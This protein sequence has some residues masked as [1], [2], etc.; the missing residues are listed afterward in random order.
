MSFDYTQ[1][2]AFKGQ[3]SHVAPR[4]QHRLARSIGLGN[5]YLKF[6]ASADRHL[7]VIEVGCGD[8]RF[9]K[10]LREAGFSNLVGVDPSA[11]YKSVTTEIPILHAYANDYLDQCLDDSVGTI[12]AFDVFEHIPLQVLRDLFALARRK[13][14][15][16]GMIVFRI[17]NMSSPLALVNFFGDTSHVTALNQNSL[18]QIF[19]D[20]GLHLEEVSPEPLAYPRSLLDLAGIFAWYVF[21]V[22]YGLV[23]RAFGIRGR[24]LTPN[25]VCTVR[26]LPEADCLPFVANRTA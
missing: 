24:V 11:T 3:S 12:V 10:T 5:R 21:K 1:Y 16:N 15:P 14:S 8:G 19:F 2:G 4:W 9:L 18:D 25:M 17:P 7:P 26:R 13:L 22:V 6:L 20:S 23:L